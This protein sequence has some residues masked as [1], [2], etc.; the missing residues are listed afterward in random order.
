M[1][2]HDQRNFVLNEHIGLIKRG[3]NEKIV[4]TILL[5]VVSDL[6]EQPY[7]GVFAEVSVR[8]S[9]CCGSRVASIN[10]AWSF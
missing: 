5:A 1:R 8:N 3:S 2:F 4:V 7:H 9:A 6:A 10:S